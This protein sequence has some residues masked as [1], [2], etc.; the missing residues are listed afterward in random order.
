MTYLLPHSR[1][2]PCIICILLHC[3]Q[4]K[5]LSPVLSF[6][7]FPCCSHLIYRSPPLCH[8]SLLGWKAQGL[9]SNRPLT[10]SPGD[11]SNYFLPSILSFC[12]CLT[13]SQVSVLNSPSKGLH[14]STSWFSA[15]TSLNS[16]LIL[17]PLHT[18]HVKTSS[19]NSLLCYYKAV[20][21]SF[22][23]GMRQ[24]AGS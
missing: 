9:L 6:F 14:L 2:D 13:V 17:V 7:W 3:F 15:F 18:H 21:E 24:T 12:G 8:P 1:Q 4:I 5:L 20:W 11:V 19:S 16:V 23:R 22:T 10:F